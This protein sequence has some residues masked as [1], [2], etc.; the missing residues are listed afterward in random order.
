MKSISEFYETVILR[1]LL[2]YATPGM[3]ALGGFGVALEALS[4]RL[5][6]NPRLFERALHGNAVEWCLFLLGAYVLGHVLTSMRQELFETGEREMT[7]EVL[8]QKENEHLRIMAKRFLVNRRMARDE[9]DAESKLSDSNSAESI[10]ET[11]RTTVKRE[12]PETYSEFVGRHSVLSRFCHNVAMSLVC[13]MALCDRGSTGRT[14]CPRASRAGVGVDS[15]GIG[16][17][18]HDRLREAAVDTCEEAPKNDDQTYVQCLR[19]I[20]A[21]A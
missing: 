11:I 14:A 15:V 8:N 20:D 1:D 9:A 19:P 12:L 2:E 3:I 7:S 13:L 4:V 17:R 5:G 10:R 21:R 18:H 16:A 6:M